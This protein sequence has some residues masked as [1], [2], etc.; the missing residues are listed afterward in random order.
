MTETVSIFGAGAFGTSLAQTFASNGVRTFLWARSPALCD[1]INAERKNHHYSGSLILDSKIHASSNKNEVAAN[2]ATWVYACSSSYFRNFCNEIKPLLSLGKPKGILLIDTSKGLEK[3]SL[4]MHS[5]IVQEVLGAD[6]AKDQFQLLS[7][8]SFAQELLENIPT[9]V[10]L[11]GLN[12]DHLLK[13]QN[14]LGA[15]NFRLYISGDPIGCQIGGAAKN[16]VAIALGIAEGLGLGQNSRAALMNRG[17]IEIAKLGESLGAKPQTF[18]G[19]SCLG[20][21]LLTCSSLM[22]RNFRFGTLLGQGHSPAEAEKIIA[23]TIEGVSSASAIFAL[24]KRQGLDLPI[25]NEVNAVLCQGKSAKD[26]YED[27]LSRPQG[28]EWF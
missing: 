7:G 11:A 10:S 22:S 12:K 1:E 15:K 19:L 6:F 17:L 4:L 3:D 8:P 16:V 14:L 28:V 26:S 23:S 2:S 9:S 20:D 24:S 13:T 21:L 27:L 25:C 5:Q 18:L